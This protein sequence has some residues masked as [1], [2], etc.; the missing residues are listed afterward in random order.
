MD[1]MKRKRVNIFAKRHRKMTDAQKL[2]R[3]KRV[4]AARKKKKSIYPEAFYL[5]H[6]HDQMRCLD[7]AQSFCAKGAS[8]G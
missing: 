2:E 8:V 6:P 4:K 7:F 5:N 1:V 3:R